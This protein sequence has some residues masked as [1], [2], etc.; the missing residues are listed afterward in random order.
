MAHARLLFFWDY[1]TQWGADR[2]RGSEGRKDWGPL[3]F[4]N[5]ERLLDL[6]AEYGI[7]ACFAVV[8]A[9][10]VP[11]ER[12]YHDPAQIQR[13]YKAGH[14]IASHSFRHEWLP[15]LEVDSLYETLSRSKD[16]LEQCIGAPVLSF[17]PPFNQPFDYP[18]RGAFS[19]SERRAVKKGRIGLRRLCEALA[20][21]GY[22]FCR[23][24]YRSMIRRLAER[25]QGLRLDHPVQLER[26]GGLNCLRL[27]TPGGF[28]ERTRR[29]VCQCVAEGGWVIVYGHPHSLFSGNSQDE[30]HLIPFL[31]LVAG[32]RDAGM[33]TVSLPR[34]FAGEG[35]LYPSL[36]KPDPELSVDSG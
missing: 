11:G 5:T 14:E 2:S 9:A 30:T 31:K 29:A 23:V 17:V 8:G 6:H 36:L 20:E 1:D 32:L 7:P 27:N 34:D 35:L 33:L 13:I 18:A 28:D 22:H 19:L 4:E 15:G 12:P 26:I 3:E 21:C 10:A 25:F 16:A 24:S